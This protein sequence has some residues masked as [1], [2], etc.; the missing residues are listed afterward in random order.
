MNKI[1]VLCGKPIEDN[2]S[3]VVHWIDENTLKTVHR[4]CRDK[5]EENK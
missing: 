5:A 3:R 2:Q 1:C 4:K